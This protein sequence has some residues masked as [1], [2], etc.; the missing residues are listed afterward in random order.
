MA[1][2]WMVRAGEQGYLAPEFE[3]KRCVAVGFDGV[4]DFA[5]I[6]S[7]EAAKKRVATA[8]PEMSPTQCAIAA[9]VLWKFRA[10]M[11]TGD[12]VVTYDPA[13]R[14]YLVGVIQ[15]EY[16]YEPGRVTDYAHVRATDWTHQVSRDD[17]KPS[18]RNSLGAL[19]TIFEPGDGVLADL[20]ASRT[21]PEVATAPEDAIEQISELEQI[22]LEQVSR[23]HEFIKDRLNRLDPAAM[24]QLVA[25]ILRAIGYRARVT[26]V[27]PDRGRDVIASPDGLGLQHP[28]IVCEVKHRRATI[29][30]PE[31]RGFVGGL[32][33]EDRGLYVSTGG[34]TREAR[35]EAD[36]S[37]V[38]VT[39]VDMDALTTL[40]VEHYESFD[41]VGRGLIP[42]QRFYWPVG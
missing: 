12:R 4:G 11:K 42:L 35:Y 36:R 9:G 10:M 2:F 29:G 40:V 30:A 33:G 37:A 17:L 38:P 24:E 5:S 22:R 13:R 21:A 41:N 32:R 8:N 14:L 26:P 25:S 19:L 6:Q 27:G 1:A 23:A 18:S 31:V 7:L 20:L 3:S 15:G 39:L 34:F 28:R 16:A